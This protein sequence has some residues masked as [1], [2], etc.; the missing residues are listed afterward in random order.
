MLQL[1]W[2]EFYKSYL[3]LEA[4]AIYM[5]I[6]FLTYFYKQIKSASFS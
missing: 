5:Q 6:Y 1:N 2:S 4:F 3:Y